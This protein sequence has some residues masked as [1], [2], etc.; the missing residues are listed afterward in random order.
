MVR[1]HWKRDDYY[2]QKLIAVDA[3][4]PLAVTPE[5][6]AATRAIDQI[7]EGVKAD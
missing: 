5:A 7:G 1:Q 3:N 2:Q 4:R 6:I